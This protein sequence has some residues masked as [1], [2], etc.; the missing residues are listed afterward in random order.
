MVVLVAYCLCTGSCYEAA[1]WAA[2]LNF[3]LYVSRRWKE[4][5]IYLA[6]ASRRLP[7]EAVG[8]SGAGVW[9]WGGVRG[10]A[11]WGLGVGGA[12]WG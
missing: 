10:G 6:V 4:S 11:V 9:W 8:T 7:G 12:G 5:G 1:H 3:R 2:S